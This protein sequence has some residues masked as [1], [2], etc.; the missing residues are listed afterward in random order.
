MTAHRIAFLAGVLAG[1][2]ALP[3]LAQGAGEWV[4]IKGAKELRSL[5][6]NNTFKGN[7][8]VGHYRADGTGTMSIDG[9]KPESRTWEVKGND[10]VCMTSTNVMGTKTRCYT[11]QRNAKNESWIQSKL[12]DGGSSFGFTVQEGSPK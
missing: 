5:Y 10:Q 3:V 2:T 1:V 11:F 9:A 6:S 7:G 12:V 8:W 4:D